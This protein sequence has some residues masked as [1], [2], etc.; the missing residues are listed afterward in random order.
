VPETFQAIL[1]VALAVLPGALYTWYFEREVGR[2]GA[3]LSDR[4]LRFVG[5]SAIF[6]AIFAFPVYWIWSNYLHRATLVG[7]KIAFRNLLLEGADLPPL[8]F[9]V[10]VAYVALPIAAG[11]L[12][13]LAVRHRKR[14]KWT[15]RI[16]R[17]VAGRDPAPRAWD[18]LFSEN[19]SAILRIRMKSG[20]RL[21][22]LF[23][24]NSYASGYPEL[25]QDLLLERVYVVDQQSGSFVKDEEGKFVETG[26]GL[27]LRW[28][29]IEVLEVFWIEE[30]TD[31]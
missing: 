7:G 3:S 2:W 19:P 5:A 22:G 21:G 23:G 24:A 29:D 10:P 31:G 13:S 4:V 26:S 6:Q 14:G 27:L 15:R 20:S 30:A 28:E 8:L 18:F 17:V 12:A 16:A 25:P 11:T 9:L 1:V